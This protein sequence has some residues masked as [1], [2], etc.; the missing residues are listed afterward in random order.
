MGGA[1]M[2]ELVRKVFS[3]Q[4]QASCARGKYISE[5]G[6]WLCFW[7]STREMPFKQDLCNFK[8]LLLSMMHRKEVPSLGIQNDSPAW[9]SIPSFNPNLQG[10]L[11]SSLP[12]CQKHLLLPSSF[13]LSDLANV[14]LTT[15]TP[16]LTKPNMTLA[17]TTD[18]DTKQT[19]PPWI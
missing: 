15:Y 5:H 18:P 13:L 2:K 16:P 1:R 11:Q 8:R 9:P 4:P 10:V 12:I 17:S 6:N 19:F 14:S 3:S 7:P